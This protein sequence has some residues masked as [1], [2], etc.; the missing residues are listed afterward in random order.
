MR[1]EPTEVRGRLA[2][3]T[4]DVPGLLSR[5]ISLFTDRE[6][7]V[8]RN[9]IVGVVLAVGAVLWVGGDLSA[10][11]AETA[12]QGTD[13]PHEVRAPA[14][15]TSNALRSALQGFMGRYRENI[16]RAAELMPSEHYDYKPT[17]DK[18]T[19]AGEL[20]HVA[21]SSVSLC[22]ALS[23]PEA[24]DAPDLSD[25]HGTD[26]GRLVSGLRQAFDYCDAAIASFDDATRA[27]EVAL[28][29]DYRDS[30]AMA[31][32]ILAADWGDHYGHLAT[33]MRLNDLLPP[34]AREES[35]G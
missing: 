27:D 8:G 7:V 5:T 31:A 16:V 17:E 3:H 1:P 32:L 20:A 9:R 33:Y 22:S 30:K 29:G 34:T 18:R 14:A 4:S 24:P 15:D 2:N 13:A 19:F 35:E 21:T 10:D 26:K 11:E 28:F 23:G 6:E 25:L 12:V